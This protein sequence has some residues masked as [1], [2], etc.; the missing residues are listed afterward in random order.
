MGCS[1]GM[2]AVLRNRIDDE[3][4]LFVYYVDKRIMYGPLEPNG[5]FFEDESFFGH[6]FQHVLA[7]T[8]AVQGFGGVPVKPSSFTKCGIIGPATVR[9][10]QESRL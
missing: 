4:K 5:D 10:R 7:C 2:H 9:L 3:T 1:R 8:A 6:Y